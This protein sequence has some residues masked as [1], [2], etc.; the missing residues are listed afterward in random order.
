MK[1]APGRL[2]WVNP[3]MEDTTGVHTRAASGPSQG[4]PSSGDFPM[5]SVEADSA[6]TDSKP[7][8][9]GLAWALANAVEQGDWAQAESLQVAILAVKGGG[10]G[11]FRKGLGKGKPGPGAAP[12]V[13]SSAAPGAAGAGFNGPGNHCRAWGHRPAEFRKPGS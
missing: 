4:N 11:G 1:A 13:G 12:P 8:D 6:A 7:S 10:K 9:G 3:P 2:P 5:N